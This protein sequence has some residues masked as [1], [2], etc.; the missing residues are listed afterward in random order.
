ML[1]PQSPEWSF[2]RVSLDSR[3]GAAGSPQRDY[4]CL[5]G[6]WRFGFLAG[7]GFDARRRPRFRGVPAVFAEFSPSAR[8]SSFS[9]RLIA[10]SLGPPMVAASFSISALLGNASDPERKSAITLR[11]HLI[12]ARTTAATYSSSSKKMRGNS[13]G[14]SQARRAALRVPRCDSPRARLN[15]QGE[16]PDPG[17]RVRPETRGTR[18]RHWRGRDESRLAGSDG[19]RPLPRRRCARADARRARPRG[20]AIS[21]ARCRATIVW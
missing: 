16:E 2:E 14:A 4:R 5:Y 11:S 19:P 20:S 10:S 6:H 8:W 18:A 17:A 3:R 7:V 13:G 15:L 9:T 12:S 1:V 21:P